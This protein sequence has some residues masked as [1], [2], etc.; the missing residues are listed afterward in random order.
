[1]LY[2]NLLTNNGVALSQGPIHVAA[3]NNGAALNF[4]SV[5]PAE[6]LGGFS[7]ATND[8]AYYTLS[9]N[10]AIAPPSP[11]TAQTF[12]PPTPTLDAGVASGTLSGTIAVTNSAGYDRGQLVVVRYASI[13]TADETDVDAA[14]SNRGGT[15]TVT[16][17]AAGTA[18]A[19]V[20][21]AYY[22]AYLRLWKTGA[23]HRAKIIPV[24]GIIDLRQ[25][26]TAS[27]FNVTIP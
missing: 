22:Y 10:T 8:E 16:G 27:G 13:I 17:L 26:N 24:N 3:Y 12:A 25:T 15:F 7:V 5:T 23:H 2:N 6:G 21:G 11:G 4:S 18:S 1:M 9:G 14:L 20:P 19:P